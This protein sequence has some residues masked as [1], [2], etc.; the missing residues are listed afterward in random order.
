MEIKDKQ[1]LKRIFLVGFHASKGGMTYE[2]A[3]KWFDKTYKTFEITD[4]DIEAWAETDK[5]I[6][7]SIE[8]INHAI[9]GAKAVLNDEIKHI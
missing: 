4:S 1:F 8:G 7:K 6:M 3:K 2:E 5:R 9:L